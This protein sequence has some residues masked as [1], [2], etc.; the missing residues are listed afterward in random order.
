MEMGKNEDNDK[1]DDNEGVEKRGGTGGK[2]NH[3]EYFTIQWEVF[4]VTTMLMMVT[5][6]IIKS[7]FARTSNSE[8]IYRLFF[9]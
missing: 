3:D 8:W 5:I 1:D 9:G 6:I 2:Q 4:I 7:S